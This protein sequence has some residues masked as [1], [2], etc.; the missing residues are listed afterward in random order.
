[1]FGLSPLVNGSSSPFAVTVGPISGSGIH[2]VSSGMIISP[3]ELSDGRAKTWKTRIMSR[4][5]IALVGRMHGQIPYLI[6]P[7][8]GRNDSFIPLPET[9]RISS[10]VSRVRT[11]KSSA[12]E[13]LLITPS[14]VL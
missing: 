5:R 6:T 4:T 3:Q 12:L 8:C 13:K 11:H 14:P 1:M 2:L 10:M 9:P 7:F